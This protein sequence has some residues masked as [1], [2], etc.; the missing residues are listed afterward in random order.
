LPPQALSFLGNEVGRHQVRTA[1]GGGGIVKVF[2][3][4]ILQQLCRF[5]CSVQSCFVTKQTRCTS[6]QACWQFRIA[7]CSPFNVVQYASALMVSPQGKKSSH[8]NAFPVPKNAG[9]D[10][11]N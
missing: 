11:Y 6:E 2:Q 3:T 1:G 9:H 8:K 4:K 5:S 7:C 10:F